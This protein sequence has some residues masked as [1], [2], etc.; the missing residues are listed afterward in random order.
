MLKTIER[1]NLSEV[2][3][4]SLVHYINENLQEGERLPY[5]RQIGEMLN[6][7]KSTVREALR[8]LE[9]MGLV[10]TKNGDGS[11]VTRNKN[12]FLIKPLQWGILDRGKSIQD[13]VEARTLIEMMIIDLAVER[14]QPEDIDKMEKALNKME[15]AKLGEKGPFLQADILSL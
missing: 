9:I 3:A 10:E 13:L 1:R 14:V 5:E 11:F 15:E 6:I 4:E 7:G 2:A 8:S 12:T